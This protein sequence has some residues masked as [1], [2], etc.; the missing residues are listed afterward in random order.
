MCDACVA[1]TKA[2][3]AFGIPPEAPLATFVKRLRCRKCGS[4]SVLANR[5]E[6]DN[7]SPAVCAPDSG[8]DGLLR[9]YNRYWKSVLSSSTSAKPSPTMVFSRYAFAKI[10]RRSAQ[11]AQTATA[12]GIAKTI[13]QRNAGVIQ[14]FCALA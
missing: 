14:L 6:R 5:I 7:L 3:A 11:A 13:R 2:L 1:G 10:C 8:S 4:G 9:A 12:N